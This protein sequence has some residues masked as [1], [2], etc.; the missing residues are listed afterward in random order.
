MNSTISYLYSRQ[1]LGIKLGLENTYALSECAGSPHESLPCVQVVGTNGKGSTSAILANILRAEGYKVGLSTSPHLFHITERLRINGQPIPISVIDK[2]IQLFKSDIEEI[3]SSFFEIITVMGLW[4]FANEKVD[5][6]IMETGLGG[7]LDSVTVCNPFVTLVTSISLDHTEILGDTI[8]QIAF[9]KAGAFKPQVPVLAVRQ[10]ED[11][12]IVL[13]RQARLKSTEIEW[14]DHLL[15]ESIEVN[16]HGIHQRK[17]ATLALESLKYLPFPLRH[18]AMISGLKTVVWPG[19]FQMLKSQPDIIFDVAHNSS[20]FTSFIEE[21]S[22]KN[23]SGSNYLIISLQSRK[24]IQ[25]IVPLLEQNFDTIICTE[26]GHSRQLEAIQIAEYFS[27]PVVINTDPVSAIQTVVEQLNPFDSLAI[28]GTHYI[29]EAIH[30]YF[31][32]SFDTL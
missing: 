6:A 25:D 5:I 24:N 10:T 8:S 1:N 2:F 21:F 15:D 30:K 26:T 27:N 20:G 28:L 29:G 14:I 7:R 23:R 3:G 18:D 16:L 32:L 9:E 19:R 13:E 4:Y 31:E 22:K 17:N 12:E 11:A